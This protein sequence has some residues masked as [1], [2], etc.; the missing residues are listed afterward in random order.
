MSSLK[1][2]AQDAHVHE[3]RMTFKTYGLEDERILLEGWLKDD[4]FVKRF[5]LD[6][7]ILPPGKIHRICVR[8]LLGGHPISI[9][10]AESEMPEVPNAECTTLRDTVKKIIGLKITHGYSDRVIQLIGGANG[11]AHMV[12]LIIAMGNAAIQGYWTN[13]L[14]RPQKTPTTRDER[15]ELEYLINSCGLWAEDGPLLRK[16]QNTLKKSGISSETM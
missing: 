6:G 14:K 9:L 12:N 1:E 2:L 7:E 10:D 5:G 11:C 4:R 3:R 15:P 8:L 16:L 13:K